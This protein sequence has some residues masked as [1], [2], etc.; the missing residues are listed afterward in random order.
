MS[1][2]DGCH[3]RRDDWAMRVARVAVLVCVAGLWAC[4]GGSGGSRHAAA[5]GDGVTVSGVVL[6]ET[7]KPAIG[8]LVSVPASGAAAST[9]SDGSFTLIVPRA[10]PRLR[11]GGPGAPRYTV[12]VALDGRDGLGAVAAKTGGGESTVA[13][14]APVTSATAELGA[15]LYVADSAQGPKG[16]VTAGAQ[17]GDTLFADPSLPSLSLRILATTVVSYPA[18]APHEIF[19]VGVSITRIPV[20]LPDGRAARMAVMVGPAD[21]AFSTAA[22]LTFP[23][24]EGAGPGATLDVLRLDPAT[25]L[26]TAVGLAVVSA[27]GSTVEGMRIASGGLWAAVPPARLP[28]T[29]IQGQVRGG[30]SRQDV[31]G[32]GIVGP[33]GHTATT[34]ADGLFAMENVPVYPGQAVRLSV[35]APLRFR[36]QYFTTA[37]V[38]AVVDGVTDWGE[39][40]VDALF[41]LPNPPPITF[42]PRNGA[43]TSPGARIVVTFGRRMDLDSIELQ[44]VRG[45]SREQSS[46]R[47]AYSYRYDGAS[48]RL[49]LIPDNPLQSNTFYTIF[50][51]TGSRD[52]DGNVV[53]G[54]ATSSRFWV[55]GSWPQPRDDQIV[56]SSLSS[57][58]GSFGDEVVITGQN[59]DVNQVHFGTVR[60]VPLWQDPQGGSVGVEVPPNIAGEVRVTVAGVGDLPFRAIANLGTLDD[61]TAAPVAGGPLRITGRGQHLGGAPTIVF[62]GLRGG[63]FAIV[64]PPGGC[65]AG[66]QCYQLTLPDGIDAGGC[67]LEVAGVP[68][69]PFF[70]VARRAVDDVPPQVVAASLADGARLEDPHGAIVLDFSEP[71]DGRSFVRV[72]GPAGAVNALIGTFANGGARLTIDPP[73]AGWP[74]DGDV[75]LTVGAD[76]AADLAGNP[77]DQDPGTPEREAF[78]LRFVAGP[79]AP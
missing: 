78:Q 31:S 5:T 43:S 37:P 27:D 2:M 44:L 66:V 6:D 76:D 18:G 8:A 68:T 29:T 23:N 56:A 49:E 45:V 55:R 71:I 41:R 32:Y 59:L 65:Q 16:S 57:A 60:A 20:P 61:G 40:S 35:V 70:V 9:A 15:P 1:R 46:V 38:T 67:W 17:A 54:D 34:D 11:V 73:G 63:G 10:D 77:L 4:G 12:R 69:D 39:L 53:D 42:S 21:V 28:T 25:G 24:S 14:K 72:D 79:A 58:M 52:V 30:V 3:R 13:D 26:W 7:G 33:F 74:T 48:T 47:G 19:I 64:A 22:E 36:Y 62:G 75:T 51:P 50:V